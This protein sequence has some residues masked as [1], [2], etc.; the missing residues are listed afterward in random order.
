MIFTVIFIYV[1][2]IIFYSANDYEKNW[3]LPFYIRKRKKRRYI[4][5]VYGLSSTSLTLLTGNLE[6][7]SIF[8]VGTQKL[9]KCLANLD[10]G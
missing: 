9:I 7:S 4:M 2:F 10:G 3:Q 1:T 8:M 5:Y 6:K